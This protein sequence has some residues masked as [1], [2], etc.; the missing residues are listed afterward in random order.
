MKRWLWLIAW[1]ALPAFADEVQIHSAMD[2][3]VTFFVNFNANS[4]E[5]LN[6]HMINKLVNSSTMPTYTVWDSMKKIIMQG[7]IGKGSQNVNL[8]SKMYFMVPDKEKPY[9]YVV[10][11]EIEM[12]I[13]A[14]NDQ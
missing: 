7:T 10:P 14:G 11:F 4:R 2:G 1:F 9:L 3:K 13:P 6:I 5:I 12:I 8:P